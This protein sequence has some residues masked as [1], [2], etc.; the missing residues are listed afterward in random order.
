MR[1][2]PFCYRQDFTPSV[3]ILELLFHLPGLRDETLLPAFQFSAP[4][5]RVGAN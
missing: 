5:W 2:P 1:L 3:C 4:L